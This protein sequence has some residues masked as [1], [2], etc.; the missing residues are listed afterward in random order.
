MLNRKKD[1]QK[2]GKNLQT[3]RPN[4]HMKNT[5][6]YTANHAKAIWNAWKSI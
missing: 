6:D 3:D 4:T 2:R 1:K 5:K